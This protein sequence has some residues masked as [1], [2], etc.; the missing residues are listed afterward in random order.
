MLWLLA[1]LPQDFVSKFFG[2][3]PKTSF[4]Q[5]TP[6]WSLSS[7]FVG[8]TELVA[9]AVILG[10]IL[11]WY[12]WTVFGYMQDILKEVFADGSGDQA[13][14]LPGSREAPVA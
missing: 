12:D 3:L 13:L 5:S 1:S 11:E 10:N 9:K 14:A 6:F 8:W 4:P 7:S 2:R